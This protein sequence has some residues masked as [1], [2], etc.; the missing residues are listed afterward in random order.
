MTGSVPHSG[1]KGKG[2]GGKGKASPAGTPRADTSLGKGIE[3]LAVLAGSEEPLRI[4]ELADLAKRPKSTVHRLLATMLE[5][6][7]V[8][9]TDDGRYAIGLRLF[10]IGSRAAVRVSLRDVAIVELRDLSGRLGETSHVGVLDGDEVVYVEKVES[11]ASI[12]MSSRVGRRNP[13]HCTG[14]GKA[15][16]AFQGD[17]EI[18]AACARE[19][20]ARTEHTITDPKKLR[21]ELTLTR[22][23]GFSIDDEEVELGLRCVGAP[24]LGD[25]GRPVAAISIAGPAARM[26]V[27]KCVAIGPDL[28]EAAGRIARGLGHWNPTPA[29]TKET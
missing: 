9:Q 17:A 2:R 23:R 14:I 22:E 26:E 5:L 19:L 25:D 3:L 15:L 28:A 21:K 11:E 7:V 6:R 20:E 13:L 10:E 27:E 24:V 18:D 4:G 29:G 1:T 16:L 8:E 12:R